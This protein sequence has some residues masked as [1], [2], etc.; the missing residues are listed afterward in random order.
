MNES[1]SEAFE[2]LVGVRQDINMLT[3]QL[4]SLSTSV[5]ELSQKV[6]S[7]NWAQ[8]NAAENTPAVLGYPPAQILSQVSSCCYSP[9]QHHCQ[10]VEMPLNHSV[11]TRC[12]AQ[13]DPVKDLHPLLVE[14][15]F[16]KAFDKA[17]VA[18][19]LSA[20]LWICQ[21]LEP[22]L[23][24]EGL[25]QPVLICLVQHLGADFTRDVPIKL[26]WLHHCSI[27]VKPNDPLIKEY[28]RPIIH[29]IKERL[30][31]A[32]PGI[33]QLGGSIVA[34]HKTLMFVLSSLLSS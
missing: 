2:N 5:D 25:S 24:P 26:T 33:A 21:R 7:L 17:M 34:Q 16:E 4:S 12:A 31:Q 29:Q 10:L 20:V 22:T 11:R 9:T 6:E 30:A 1:T 27:C 14:G 13:I 3:Q 28:A 19:D 8:K 15:N 32:T 23:V 18:Q